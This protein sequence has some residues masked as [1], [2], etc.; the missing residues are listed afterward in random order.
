M[1]EALK[2]ALEALETESDIYRE[3]DDDGAPEYILEAIT[4]IKAALAKQAGQSNFCAQCEAFA[5]ELKAVKQE[6]GEPFGYW[7]SDDPAVV[8]Y[9]G[10]GFFK[11]SKPPNDAINIIPLYTTPPAQLA[12]EPVTWGVDWGKSGDRPC[13]VIT[14]RLANGGNEVLAVEFAPYTYNEVKENA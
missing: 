13:A 2:L 14:R 5:R 4:A 7:F 10:S 6:Q 1:K 12:Q 11:G 9:A 3:N 8:T